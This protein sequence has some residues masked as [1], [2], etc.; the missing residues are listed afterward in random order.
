MPVGEGRPGEGLDPH[1]E[2]NHGGQG[3][4]ANRRPRWAFIRSGARTPMPQEGRCCLQNW[5][6]RKAARTSYTKGLSPVHSILETKHTGRQPAQRAYFTRL[7][8]KSD[9]ILPG[10]GR[11]ACGNTCCPINSILLSSEVDHNFGDKGG[12]PPMKRTFEARFSCLQN[13]GYWRQ[14]LGKV[15]STDL[16]LSPAFGDKRALLGH[17][18]SSVARPLNAAPGARRRNLGPTHG[19]HHTTSKQ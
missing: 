7:S 10:G 18:R 6:Q 1:Q 13:P 8:P 14:A 9:R 12:V 16:S 2:P 19:K 15:R 11:P 5:R 3:C 4:Q 17:W